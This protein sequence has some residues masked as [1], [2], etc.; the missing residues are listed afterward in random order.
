MQDAVGLNQ[1]DLAA[2]YFTSSS[3]LCASELVQKE[4]RVAI[5]SVIFSSAKNKNN[6]LLDEAEN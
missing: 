3:L 4:I 1:R 2:F 6:K 5:K